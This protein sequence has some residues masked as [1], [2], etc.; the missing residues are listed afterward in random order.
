MATA[1]HG[2]WR[3]TKYELPLTNGREYSDDEAWTN[4]EEFIK[5]VVPVAEQAGVRI[6]IHPDDPPVPRLGG[7]P[8]I[9]SRFDDY[10]R[11]LAIANS[12]NIGVCL[13][14]G[15]WLEGGPDMGATVEEAIAHFAPKANCSR[16]TSE[17]WTSRC[18]TLSRRS[19]TM[20]TPTC[21]A[22]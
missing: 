14:A 3:T 21:S 2:T 12:P 22:S 19:S 9:F 4:F 1:T 11:A 18:R 6:G 17:T 10:K 13:C 7:A 20:G 15:C 16:S 8:R 5:Q